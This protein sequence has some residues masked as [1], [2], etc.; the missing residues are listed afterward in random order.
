MTK[1]GQSYDQRAKARV[2]LNAWLSYDAAQLLEALVEAGFAET[3]RDV[4]ERLLL[5]FGRQVLLWT[6]KAETPPRRAQAPRH[7]PPEPAP[8]PGTPGALAARVRASGGRREATEVS[9]GK[10]VRDGRRAR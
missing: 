7:R 8:A 9:S 1:Q 6:P 2:P 3:K 5:E 10:K 4:L